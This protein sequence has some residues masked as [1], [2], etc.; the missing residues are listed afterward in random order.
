MLSDGIT[1]TSGSKATGL[2]LASGSTFPAVPVDG[3][4][5]RLTQTVGQYAPGAYWY[6]QSNTRW[7]TGDI[8]SVTV[9]TG[10]SGGGGFGDISIN[11]DLT[12]LDARYINANGDSL[13]GALVLAA[14]PVQAMEAATKQ[15][16]DAV[17][18]G[19][20]CKASVR[21]ATTANVG[22]SGLGNIDGVTPLNGDRILVKNQTTA[23]QNGIYVASAS[24]WVRASDAN[25][26][27]EVTTG[28]YCF[29]EEGTTQGASGW[30][31]I[32]TGNIVLGT[33]GLSF[34][35]FGQAIAYSAGSGLQLTGN[36]FSIGT[37]TSTHV[38]NGLG[39]I[40]YNATNPSGYIS[41]ITAGM[42]NTA[43]TYTA[44]QAGANSNITSLSGLTT[45][46]TVAQGGTG[47]ITGPLALVSLG[48][49]AKGG[50]TMTGLLTLSA[51][52]T[53]A[54]HAATKQYV[55]AVAQGLDP[56]ASVRAATTANI[57]LS[58]AQ[59]IDGV[60]CVAG[61]RV[62][63]K[64]QTTGSQNGIY[65]VAS[66]AWTRATDA[67]TSAK[68]TAGMYCFVEEGTTLAAT[69]WNLLTLAITLG[70]TA[71]V[72]SQFGAATSYSAGAGITFNGSVISATVYDIAGSILGK[73]AASAV[74]SRFVA[75]RPFSFPAGM[76]NSV[77][78]NALAATASTVLTLAKN[79]TSFGTITIAASGTTGTFAA[80]SQ[81]TF[82]SGD[83]LTVTA[84]ASAD[85][86]FGDCEF[87]LVGTLT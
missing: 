58:G 16:V 15:Y 85:A 43:L 79:G 57:T 73:P 74:V 45:A 81:T 76:T 34:T 69:G 41:G 67:D 62:L 25:S 38:T 37:L 19:L 2:T 84:P 4:Y 47:A 54:L 33:T 35:Q 3:Q 24:A 63:V 30:N 10:L 44:A 7:V 50:D 1:L 80:A 75:V 26:S 18:Q 12:Y 83:I 9:G 60:A 86:T 11:L 5:F 77:S 70:T 36:T 53:N 68:V 59:T 23:N 78:K 65:I 49:L 52:P 13:T 21:L 6:D 20:D 71:L 55:D 51:D 46:L 17:A 28:M 56:K 8:S 82:A 72:F 66:G 29:V 32:T 64:N 31:L 27:A 14:D 48:A 87:T 61:N 39:Y 22:L 42:V 40:P